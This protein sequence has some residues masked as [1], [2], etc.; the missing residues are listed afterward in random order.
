M[1]HR[2]DRDPAT[3]RPGVGAPRPVA[4]IRRRFDH[5]QHAALLERFGIA[6][7]IVWRAQNRLSRLANVWTNGHTAS[8]LAQPLPKPRENRT[9]FAVAPQLTKTAQTLSEQERLALLASIDRQ[10]KELDRHEAERGGGR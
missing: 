4:A 2:G 7:P 9:V 10:L 6:G 1:V 3:G 8:E 5:E